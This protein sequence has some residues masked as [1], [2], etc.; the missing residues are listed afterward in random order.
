MLSNPMLF[1][2]RQAGIKGFGIFARQRIARGSRILSERPLLL[3]DQKEINILAAASRLSKAELDTLLG[4]SV[5]K[6]K[7]ESLWNLVDALFQSAQLPLSKKG[8]R[9]IQ[10]RRDILACFYNN[11]FALSLSPPHRDDGTNTINTATKTSAARGVFPTIA[12]LNHSCI[13]NAQGNFN[14]NVDEGSFTIH[15]LRE[16]AAGE[17]ITVSYLHDELASHEERQHWLHRVY[18]FWCQCGICAG[19]DEAHRSHKRRQ[20]LR[21]ELSKAFAPTTPLLSDSLGLSGPP[22]TAA[23][24]NAAQMDISASRQLVNLT[25]ETYE[26]EGLVGGELASLYGVAAALADSAGDHGEAMRLGA[27]SMELERDA[28][29]EDSPLYQMRRQSFESM[30]FDQGGSSL[31]R[32]AAAAPKAQSS[33]DDN[34]LSYAPWT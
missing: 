21:D 24:G 3:V 6:A 4:L 25:I 23:V 17:E 1:E 12:R 22:N 15:A 19:G 5:N 16:I 13:P 27:R 2:V 20:R 28:A 9:S 7:R 34:A 26:Q 10:Q 33:E 11:N 32:F 30:Q 31:S 29:G 8:R 18:G 14:R